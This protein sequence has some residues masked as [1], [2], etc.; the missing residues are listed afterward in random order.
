[1]S[2]MLYNQQGALIGHITEI[3][4]YHVWMILG[5]SQSDKK[6]E[7]SLCYYCKAKKP[8]ITTLKCEE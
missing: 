8:A 6:E 5:L 1:M 7:V 2:V 3:S 4:F